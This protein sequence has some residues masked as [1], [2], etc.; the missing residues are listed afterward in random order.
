MATSGETTTKER[1]R[2]RRVGCELW[3]IWIRRSGNVEAAIAD[4]SQAGLFVRTTGVPRI[5]ELVRLEVYVPDDPIPLAL[6][7]VVRSTRRHGPHGGFGV[8]LHTVDDETRRRWTALYSSLGRGELPKG[9]R[10]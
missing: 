9:G 2:S 6:C 5:G 10:R 1:R 7:V 3:A 4:V 8:E